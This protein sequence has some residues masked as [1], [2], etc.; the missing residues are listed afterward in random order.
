MLEMA[1]I[2]C[3][4]EVREIGLLRQRKALPVRGEVSNETL[5]K[6]K[7]I[8][9]NRHSFKFQHLTFTALLAFKLFNKVYVQLDFG[10]TAP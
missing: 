1:G 4:K 7:R 9:S 5:L 3:L 8:S 6:C 2:H 10:I